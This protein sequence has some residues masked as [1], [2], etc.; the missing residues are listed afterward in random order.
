MRKTEYCVTCKANKEDVSE[1]KCYDGELIRVCPNCHKE[2]N[3][4]KAC[5]AITKTLRDFD[6]SI[7]NPDIVIV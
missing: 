4:T 1:F 2:L 7:L 3:S 6:K 5:M